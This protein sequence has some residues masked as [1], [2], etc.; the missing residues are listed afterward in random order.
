MSVTKIYTENPF[1]DELV[2]YVKQIAP[3]C[4][5]K[6]ETEA[7]NNETVASLQTS[8]LYIACYEGR[9]IYDL[10]PQFP[11]EVLASVGIPK[12]LQEDYHRYKDHI[13]GIYHKSLTAAFMPYYVEH[14]EEQNNYY[15][16]IMG[17]PKYNDTTDWVYLTEDI[18]PKGLVV[19]YDIPLHLQSEEIISAL[20]TSGAIEQLI[21]LNPEKTY[22]KYIGK[23]I[24]IY[25][26]RLAKNFQ[27]LYIPSCRSD[28]VDSKFEQKF[29]LNRDY[30]LR[31][32]YSD[33][34]KFQSK[35]YDNIMTI[36][37][38]IQTMVDVI[39]EV[40]ENIARRDVF[41]ARC[42]KYIF[43]SYG[44]PF[45]DVIPIKYQIKMM[46]NINRLLKYKSTPTCMFDLCTIFGF[47]SVNIFKYYLLR[48]RKVDDKGEY[49]FMYEKGEGVYKDT[50]HPVQIKTTIAKSDDGLQVKIPY[51]FT[52]Y[53]DKGNIFRVFVNDYIVYEGTS[54]NTY[55]VN[56]DICVFNMPE[57]LKYDI[58]ARYGLTEYA[59]SHG[60]SLRSD[61]LYLGDNIEY[62]MAEVFIYFDKL[63]EQEIFEE[64]EDGEIYK[65][66]TETRL[67]YSYG[68]PTVF[69]DIKFVFYYTDNQDPVEPIDLESYPIYTKLITTAVKED[70]TIE[71]TPPEG[72]TKNNGLINVTL[73]SAWLHPEQYTIT[74]YNP[75]NIRINF[76]AI[77]QIVGHEAVILFVYTDKYNIHPS[78]KSQ[79][80]EADGPNIAIPAPI[81][82]YS[83]AGHELF[84]TLGGTLLSSDRY[85]TT[86]DILQMLDP[87]DVIANKRDVNYNFFYI[88]HEDP[89]YIIIR[90]NLKIN[91][92]QRSFTIDVPSASSTTSWEVY[93]DKNDPLTVKN[94]KRYTESAQDVWNRLGIT[95][96]QDYVRKL[97]QIYVIHGTERFYDYQ[98]D[99]I[100]NNTIVF[101]DSS[102]PLEEG[103][104]LTV[105]FRVPRDPNNTDI[106]KKDI[107]KV[108]FIQTTYDKQRVFKM[109][110]PYNKFVERNN[111]FCVQIHGRILTPDAYDLN[112]TTNTLTIFSVRDALSMNDQLVVCYYYR[113]MNE[114]NIAFKQTM[115]TA[116]ADD[117]NR[118]T[119]DFPFSD[120]LESGNGFF[121]TVGGLLMD[122]NRYEIEK[123]E[124][125][126]TLVFKEE[127]TIDTRYKIKDEYSTI[128]LAK[129]NGLYYNGAYL[130]SWYEVAE[131]FDDYDIFEENENG[132]IYAY[133]A[134]NND[135][136]KRLSYG[137][138]VLTPKIGKGHRIVFNFIY[139][140]IYSINSDYINTKTAYID[141]SSP[142]YEDNPITIPYPYQ[143][144]LED[145]DSY[146]HISIGTHVIE[147]MHYDIS[148]NH[149]F[150]DNL[151]ELTEKYG[152]T[153]IRFDFIY[154]KTTVYE[155]LNEVKDKSYNLMFVKAP[156][157]GNLDDY[158][159][160]DENYLDYNTLTSGDKLWC[161]DDDAEFV[162]KQIINEEFTYV[163]TKYISIDDIQNMANLIL[164]LPYFFNLFF[165]NVKLENRLTVQLYSIK[166]GMNFRLNDVFVFMVIMAFEYNNLVDTITV[167]LAGVLYLRG[168]N[169][170]ADIPK[171]KEDLAE[172]SFHYEYVT[173]TAFNIWA[174]MYNYI[175]TDDGVVQLNMDNY[176]QYLG[177]TVAMDKVNNNY[178]YGVSEDDPPGKEPELHKFLEIEH[179]L[180][181]FIIPTKVIPTYEY[182]LNLYKTDK[183]IMSY[184]TERMLNANNKH[185]YD[186]YKK[187]YDAILKIKYNR[188]FFINAQG[189]GYCDTYSEFLQYRNI[190]LYNVVSS[191]RLLE[192]EEKQ[193][194]ILEIMETVIK[195][196]SNYLD[197]DEYKNLFSKFPGSNTDAVK[198]YIKLMINFF[199]SYKIDLAGINTI[200]E[201]DN[202]AENAIKPIDVI[203][204]MKSILEPRTDVVLR[205]GIVETTVHETKSDPI[206]IDD[207]IY[208]YADIVIDNENMDYCYGKHLV[209]YYEN[210][211]LI[212]VMPY[213][214][215]TKSNIANYISKRVKIKIH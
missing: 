102:I 173:L 209:S 107:Y 160:N 172:N 1:V 133:H 85:R 177:K 196:I 187:I 35:Y 12:Y 211:N 77:D 179:V 80:Q 38:I 167:N 146:M 132:D 86:N 213:I 106:F 96:I 78:K 83:S 9:A 57:I 194:K 137:K 147:P 13:P 42:I 54:G 118:F 178:L 82:N 156:L 123:T 152:T 30:I 27:L 59:I 18:I 189:T 3:N 165:D 162:K 158:M 45:Y 28:I 91:L 69:R 17:L 142:Y 119:I 203:N 32:V 71:C 124:T 16:M 138:P 150:I 199:K 62:S 31:T 183:K 109:N 56:G 112:L 88:D 81:P 186:M 182:L 184:I 131:N 53:K 197:S 122:P 193:A 136:I 48:N 64:N 120:Y 108:A 168:F 47:D 7:N 190:V 174:N 61:G 111:K 97:Y 116:I 94:P 110:W 22:L 55:F 149:I 161:G 41:D 25:Q 36:F 65:Y 2:Y 121:V 143:Q 104:T 15:R 188:E 73:N 125:E 128:Y 117:T 135:P 202:K 200:F 130:A 201:L 87:Y 34:M 127:Y 92:G 134:I 79:E 63:L 43:L 6:N 60:Y 215:L 29:A 76:Y 151:K 8:D 68:E 52:Q 50:S 207:M 140:S 195:E 93:D 180:D 115:A 114:F 99:I 192:Q 205:D 100:N 176:E 66:H 103:T 169:F 157:D 33:A 126:T 175:Y 212:E 39:N 49:I 170:K 19:D 20:E 46:K 208:M 181:E 105:E 163:R 153:K 23:H 26:A 171:L 101:N 154:S 214:I 21:Q 40:Q 74:S 89:V 98:Y 206:I 24:E 10:I 67:E 113:K 129:E 198:T 11:I 159:R 204:R 144:F 141:S 58:I 164:D 145:P 37:I 72:F 5:I 148:D 14:Y 75:L 185:E 191:V 155:V 210:D 90:Q 166:P 95:T 51:P 70:G 139:H 84:A 4:I 44:I